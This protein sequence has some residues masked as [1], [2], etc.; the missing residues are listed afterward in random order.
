MGPMIRQM[1][2]HLFENGTTLLQAVF[3]QEWNI[4]QATGGFAQR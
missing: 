1:V 4:L 3:Q 2:A